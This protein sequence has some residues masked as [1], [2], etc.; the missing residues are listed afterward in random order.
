MQT[1]MLGAI[2][3]LFGVDMA[4]KQYIEENIEDTDEKSFCGSRIVIRKI[5][6]RGFALS[7]MEDEPEKVKQVSIWTTIAIFIM[8]ALESFRDGHRFRKLALVL[9]SAGAASNTYDRVVRGKVID[10]IGYRSPERAKSQ[11]DSG[12]RRMIQKGKDF[13]ENITANLA[14]IYIFLGAMIIWIR[15]L[16]R[17]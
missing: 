14:D 12:S 7:S 17:K 4:V 1:R 8:T 2:G 10:Y 9:L 15:K 3:T 6:N 13:L 16:F 11:S 5:Y